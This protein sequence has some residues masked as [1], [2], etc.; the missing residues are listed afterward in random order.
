MKLLVLTVKDTT[1][2]KL[3]IKPNMAVVKVPASLSPETQ[4]ELRD[5]LIKIADM[6]RDTKQFL[7]LFYK[8]GTPYMFLNQKV[9]KNK[10]V[11]KEVYKYK[12]L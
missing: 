8:I 9:S 5:K 10:K 12:E 11:T 7:K 1:Q 4:A 2:A 3:T 6:N